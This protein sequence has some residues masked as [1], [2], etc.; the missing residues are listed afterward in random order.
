MAESSTTDTKDEQE[1]TSILVFLEQ[2]AKG[3][4]RDEMSDQLRDMIAAVQEHGKPGSLTLKL[5]AKRINDGQVGIEASVTAKLPDIPQ[6]S[7]WFATDGGELTRDDPTQMA[8]YSQEN[9]NR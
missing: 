4:T 8:L 7:I 5:T 9:N 2:H 3:R 1:P 6:A